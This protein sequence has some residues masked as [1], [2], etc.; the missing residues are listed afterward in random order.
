MTSGYKGSIAETL[1][2]TIQNSYS[3]AQLDAGWNTVGGMV[4]ILDGGLVRNCYYAGELEMM[5]GELQQMQ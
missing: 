1:T 2:G 4:G 5:N 3:T